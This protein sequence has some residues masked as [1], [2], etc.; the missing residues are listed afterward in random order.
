MGGF[1]KAAAAAEFG[2]DARFTPVVVIAVGQHQA[3]HGLP[4]DLAERETAPRERRPLSES[5]LPGTT[6]RELRRT[7]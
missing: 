4:D 2:I 1:D 7:A 6:L 5:V 3:E